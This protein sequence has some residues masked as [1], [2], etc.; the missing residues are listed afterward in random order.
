MALFISF[1]DKIKYSNIKQNHHI[2]AGP[3]TNEKKKAKQ[4]G[5]R[6]RDS[7]IYTLSSPIKLPN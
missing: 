7:L 3:D 5:T 4:A 2:K 6:I 1:F